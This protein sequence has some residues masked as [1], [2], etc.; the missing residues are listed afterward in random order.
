MVVVGGEL[1]V[2][3]FRGLVTTAEASS[4]FIWVLETSTPVTALCVPPQDVPAGPTGA[5]EDGFF[6]PPTKGTSPAQVAAQVFD[7]LSQK[8]STLALLFFGFSPC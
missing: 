8:L 4:D 6:V 2:G 7:C 3:F 1:C 5:A